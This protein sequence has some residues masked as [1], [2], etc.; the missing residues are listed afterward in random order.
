MTWNASLVVPKRAAGPF[1]GILEGV[2]ID[3]HTANDVLL[4]AFLDKPD[5][6]EALTRVMGE[7]V[8]RAAREAEGAA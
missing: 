7:A 1:D 5:F 3:R 2:I 4:T 8:Y 6:R